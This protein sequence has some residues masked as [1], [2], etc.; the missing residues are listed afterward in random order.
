MRHSSDNDN[1]YYK[2]DKY[3]PK[4]NKGYDPDFDEPQRESRNSKYSHI[5]KQKSKK[6]DNNEDYEIGNQFNASNKVRTE[7]IKNYNSTL[8]GTKKDKDKKDHAVFDKVIDNKTRYQ[9]Q[10]FQNSEFI[11]KMNGCISAGKEANVYHADAPEGKEYAIK[12]YKVETMVFRD[13][14]EYIEGE[15]RFKN[16]FCKS[17]PRKMIKLWAEKEFRN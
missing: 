3:N 16:G 8:E 12:I 13:R 5:A 6:Q 1:Q 7:M 17:N 2:E 4:K 9:I 10:K 15:R 14:E 11:T